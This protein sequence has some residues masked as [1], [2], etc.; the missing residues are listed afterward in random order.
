M[1][2]LVAGFSGTTRL[3]VLVLLLGA[4][5]GFAYWGS[6]PSA[7]VLTDNFSEPL[8]GATSAKVDIDTGDGNLTIDRLAGGE[9]VLASGTLQYFEKQG[10][11]TRTVNVSNGQA[12]LTV[13]G[14]GG[15]I[16]R[17]WFRFPW[18]ACNG[19]FEW[20]IHLNPSVSYDIT[21]RSGGGNVRLDLAGLA[22][23]RLS[24]DSGGGNMDVVLPDNAADLSVT[25]KTG[26]GNV[27]IEVGPGTT[28]SNSVDA[29]SGAGNVS[30]R[31]P[32]G[33]AARIHATTGLGKVIVDPRFVRT[34]KNTYQSP[35]YDTAADRVE[36][37]VKSGAGN[38]SVDTK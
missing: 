36:I 37:T 3:V 1:T 20:Q 25:A 10:L 31:V 16:G 4:V 14:S 6:I 19:A 29:G 21:A 24:A 35:G 11:P 9:Q 22:L 33:I 5:G 26:A 2:S 12:T 30:V 13:R 18:A 38:V 28:G 8:N 7:N 27:A 17:P 15:A 34:E 23:A 32:S